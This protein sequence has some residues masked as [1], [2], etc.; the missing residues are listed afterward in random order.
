MHLARDLDDSSGP[1]RHREPSSGIVASDTDLLATGP[2][3]GSSALMA[4]WPGDD[5]PPRL[6]LPEPVDDDPPIV[7]THTDALAALPGGTGAGAVGR[8]QVMG[9]IARGGMGAVLRARDADLGRD[10]ALKVLLERHRDDEGVIRRFVEEAQIGGQLQHPG[11]VP[12]H[13]LGALADRRPFFTMKLVKGRTLAALLAERNSTLSLLPPGATPEGFP[14]A[15]RADEGAAEG[16]ARASEPGPSPQPSPGGRG[17]LSDL[18]RFLSIFEQVCQTV[19]YA[20]ARRVIHRDLKPANVMVGH[21]GEVQVMDWGLAKVLPEGGLADEERARATAGAET[22]IETVRSGPGGSGS[23]SQAG[24]V[25]G[26]PSYMAPEQARGEV[27][28]IDERSDVFGLGAILCEILTGRPPFVGQTR[29]AIRAQAERADLADALARLDACGADTELI[30]L[31]KGCLA[32]ERDR[33][34]RHAGE[35]ARRISAYQAGVQE[36][37][38][39]AERA[40]VE[41]QTRAAE[42]RKRRRVTVALTAS[43]LVTA[44]VIGGGW[45]YLARQQL[46]RAAQLDLALREAEVLRDEAARAG[47]DLARWLAARDAAH[48][49]GRP[50]ADARDAA[51]RQRVTALVQ[52]VTQATQAAEADQKLL[53]KLVDIRS[54]EADDPD[55]SVSDAAYADAFRE[56]GI[57]MATLPPAEAGA[58]IK[59][60][61]ASVGLA[62]AAS[63][64]DWAF[65]RRGARPKPEEGWKG[66]VAAAR[67]ADPDPRRNRLRELWSQSDR[68][69]Q[70]EALRKLAQ[71]ADP[72]TWPVQSLHL[73]SG[74][75]D[76]AGDRDAAVAL[77]L[78]AWGRHPGDVGINLDLGYFLERVRPPRTE[79]AIRFY[80]MARALRPETAHQLAHALASRGRGAEAVAVFR[81]LVRL[82]PDYGGHQSCYGVLLKDRGDR[83]G[84]EEALNRAVASLRKMTQLKPADAKALHSLGFALYHQGKLAEATTAYREA[85]R[86]KPDDPLA[87]INL[88]NA[89]RDQGKRAEAIAEF[90]EALRLK[91]DD[92]RA[93]VNLGVALRG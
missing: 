13:E 80:S 86:L 48:A 92:P 62:L 33:R 83:A 42:E 31:A 25:L 91:P 2:P 82:R 68:K 46:L 29:E 53:A 28:R 89:L 10:L 44:G 16:L 74:V 56:A 75:L 57:D 7:W 17:S 93:R 88:G 61:P 14:P 54:A 81:D 78:R 87:R 55:G 90:R 12:V 72:E 66:L 67:A 4:L 22:M 5:P 73:L 27:E 58:M 40:R 20:H 11:I 38:Q 85:L 49:T 39:T 84:A 26:T 1:P 52:Q 50:L 35:V 21:F 51:T 3:P 9:E 59:A 41:A 60:R 65:Q 47:D 70:L 37:L 43:V 34:P 19:A 23:E 8:Y 64:D 76:D 6:L 30:A 63:L 71:G 24:S 79:E 15:R 77:L 18:P 45:A 32:A 36:R 69:G